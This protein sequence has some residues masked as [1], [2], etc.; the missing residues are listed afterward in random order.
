VAEVNACVEEI[1]GCCIHTVFKARITSP[2]ETMFLL[3]MCL[4]KVAE[5]HIFP[6]RGGREAE[7]DSSRLAYGKR[8][9]HSFHHFA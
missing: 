4:V 9:G 2:G 5:C 1:F 3:M 8:K 7:M 6:T